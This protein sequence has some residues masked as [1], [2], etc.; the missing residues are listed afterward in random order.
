MPRLGWRTYPLLAPKYIS[1][2]EGYVTDVVLQTPSE[3]SGQCSLPR[4]VEAA[5]S[6]LP[7]ATTTNYAKEKLAVR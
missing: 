4:G 5:T 6:R 2:C 7:S 3:V 1:M